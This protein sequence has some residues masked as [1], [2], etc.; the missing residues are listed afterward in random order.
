MSRR[1]GL[2][3]QTNYEEWA[4]S[5]SRRGCFTV[6][7][8]F[9]WDLG[10]WSC[11]SSSCWFLISFGHIRLLLSFVLNFSVHLPP[12]RSR[13]SGVSI[14]TGY[15]LDDRLV[16]VRG[17]VGSRI[18]YSP[19]RQDGSG[20]HHPPTQWVPGAFSPGES[21]QVREADH[22]PPPSAEDQ[23]IW[24]FISTSPYAFMA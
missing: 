10:S 11:S 14:A 23:K 1:H 4:Y 6:L 24:I 7:V 9:A 2:R 16:E 13:D 21:Q 20:V 3:M 12:W 18:F 19:R 15:G 8:T 5:R 17:Q 22:L